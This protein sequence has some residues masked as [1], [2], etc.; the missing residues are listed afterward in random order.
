MSNQPADGYDSDEDVEFEDVPI[1]PQRHSSADLLD[2][3]SEH[4]GPV[5]MIIPWAP[6]LNIPPQREAPLAPGSNA[7]MQLRGRLSAGIDRINSR[8]MKFQLGVDGRYTGIQQ[9]A[10]DIEGIADMLWESATP[11]IQVEGLISLAGLLERNLRSYPFDPQPTLT[12][13]NKLDYYLTALMQG[14]H[15]ESN[16][17]LPGADADRPLVTPTQRVRIRSIAETTRTSLFSVMPQDDD[18]DE[19][20]GEG[21][22]GDDDQEEPEMPG[23][24]MQASRVYERVLMLLGDL[25]D[26]NETGEFLTE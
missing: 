1:Q 3:P 7:E 22:T 13:L 23:W 17:R 16:V 14:E 9:L 8:H 21:E 11:T 26:P 15:P 2:R 18:E 24:M 19:G 20:E 5:S 12:I 10:D 4:A 25:G 6:A